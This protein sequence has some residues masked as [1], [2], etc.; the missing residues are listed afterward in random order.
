MFL[1]RRDDGPEPLRSGHGP[2]PDGRRRRQQGN[3]N[4]KA[5]ARL[6]ALFC[7]GLGRHLHGAWAHLR[8]TGKDVRECRAVL[9]VSRRGGLFADGAPPAWAAQDQFPGPRRA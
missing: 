7:P 1:R 8:S 6:F 3:H 5:L 2:A 9:E 4:R